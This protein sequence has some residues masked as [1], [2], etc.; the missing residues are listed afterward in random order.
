[1]PRS[2]LPRVAAWLLPL[3][4]AGLSAAIASDP[5]P[6]PSSQTG[7]APAS[8]VSEP[9][10]ATSLGFEWA[11]VFAPGKPAAA[12][13]YTRTIRPFF[14][15]TQVCDEIRNARRICYLE[16]ISHG[17]AARLNW[18]IALTKDGRSMALIMLP[19]D[20]SV[21][22]GVTV[23][24]GGFTRVVK[25]LICDQA[26]CA[27]TFPADAALI[28]LLGRE[29]RATIVFERVGKPITIMASLRGLMLALTDLSQSVAPATP[30]RPPAA[31]R[32][33]RRTSTEAVAATQ[34]DGGPWKGIR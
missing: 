29:D 22:V 4:L 31:K 16:T 19:R 20:S 14:D 24:F 5:A 18:R 12:G 26:L 30:G 17:D 28:S 27:A 34:G 11:S 25:P 33:A 32:F 21:E 2:R 8:I 6:R 1:M 3:A 7:A 9:T 15:W 23:S 10:K 13:D